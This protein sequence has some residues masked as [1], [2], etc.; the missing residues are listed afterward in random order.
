ME[1]IFMDDWYIENAI[2]HG[3]PVNT[4]ISDKNFIPADKKKFAE[5]LLVM[6]VPE[7]GT[8]LETALFEA[9][10]SGARVMLYGSTKYASEQLRAFLGLA[11]ADKALD[12]VLTVKTSLTLDTA[13]VGKRAETL[14]HDALVSNG[15]I[16]EV[17]RGEGASEVVCTASANGE[18]RVYAVFARQVRQKQKRQG[19]L[20]ARLVP[21]QAQDRGTSAAALQADRELSFGLTYA[22]RNGALRLSDKL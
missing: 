2:D 17:S 19:I 18:T 4:V 21:A 16:Y 6:P 15:G 20:G 11:L 9:L 10:D 1:R 5:T 7:E 12:G 8:A 3:F 13:E 22:C 14:M